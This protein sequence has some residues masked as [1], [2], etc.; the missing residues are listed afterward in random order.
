MRAGRGGKR[1]T[2]REM[3][4]GVGIRGRRAET[5]VKPR[6]QA[7]LRSHNIH[8]LDVDV[9]HTVQL[10]VPSGGDAVVN[11]I[12]KTADGDIELGTTVFK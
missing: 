9:L 3:F 6:V 5:I 12:V 1:N 11:N 7:Q 2:L 4:I 8:L 10:L